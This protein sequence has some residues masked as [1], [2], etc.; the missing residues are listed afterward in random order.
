MVIEIV[1]K[2]GGIRGGGGEKG[3]EREAEGGERRSWTKSN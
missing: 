3:R 2:K 1:E